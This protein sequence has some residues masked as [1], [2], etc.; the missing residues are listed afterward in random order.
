[1]QLVA[2]LMNVVLVC[3]NLTVLLRLHNLVTLLPQATAFSDVTR[4]F[5]ELL[6]LFVYL[7]TFTPG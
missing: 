2:I 4:Q 5:T 1:M 7:R 6:T 3:I